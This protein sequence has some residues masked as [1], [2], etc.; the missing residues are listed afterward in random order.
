MS[1]KSA[2][3]LIRDLK[4]HG[5]QAYLVG[6]VVRDFLMKEKFSDIDIT[7]NAKPFEV[8]KHFKAVPSGIKYGTVTILYDNLQFEVTTFRTDGPTSD[9]RHPDSVIYSDNV[10][11]DV[12]RRDFTINGILMDEYQNI[13]DYVGGQK[14]IENKLIRAIGDP[15]T[16]FNEDALRILRALYFQSKLGFEIEENTKEAMLNNRHLIKEL[17]MERVHKELIKILQGKHLKMAIQSIID[18][19]IH[20]VLPGLEKGILWVNKLEEMPFIDTFFALSFTLNKGIIPVEWTFSNVHRN[21]YLK[22]SEVA[23]NYPKEIS[24]EALYQYGLEICLLANKVNFNLGKQKYLNRSI[25]DRFEKLP[26]KSE[27]DLAL[28]S[29]EIMNIKNKKAGIWLGKIKKEMIT[30][31][32]NKKVLNTKESL[33]KYVESKEV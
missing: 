19:K 7:T 18:T 32:L 3:N 26:I 2:K 13:Y 22:A 5:Y 1:I 6:G 8:M 15:S 31:I 28:T 9:F 30:D 23:L 27:L 10:T 16:R 14:D 24:D 4:K 21:K 29:Q 25:Q 17:A 33:T 12:H 20:E 11:D